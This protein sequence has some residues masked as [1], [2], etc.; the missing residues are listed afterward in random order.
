M[1]RPQEIIR[2]K[3]DGGSL[4][5]KEIGN[6][7]GGVTDGRWADYQIS[8]LLMACFTRGLNSDEQA[9]LTGAMLHSG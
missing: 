8:A 3:R 4:T 9:F 7:V 5:E 6:F 2:K 1:F